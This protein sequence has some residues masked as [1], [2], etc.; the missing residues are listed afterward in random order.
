MST[1]LLRDVG[2]DS[3]TK[4]QTLEN[5]APLHQP[6]DE[7]HFDDE[8]S[9][10]KARP[11]VPLK[12]FDERLQRRRR[13]FLFGMFALAMFLGA[14]SGL[15]SA[16]FKLREVSAEPVTQLAVPTLRASEEAL[17]ST[18]SEEPD[19]KNSFGNPLP[20]LPPLEEQ[21]FK[22]FTPKRPVI[23]PRRVIIDTK[24]SFPLPPLSEEEEFARN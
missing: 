8:L 2:A 6:P 1:V 18:V 17:P 13:W 19:T 15:I 16:H 4:E 21:Q 14:A 7:P 23:R 3:M 10:L 12:Q 22:L 20:G 24:H 11:V 9:I 5:F